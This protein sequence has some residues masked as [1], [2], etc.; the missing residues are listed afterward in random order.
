MI[1]PLIL[2]GAQLANQ[3]LLAY[4]QNKRARELRAR[5]AIDPT[6]SAFRQAQQGLENQANNAQVAGYGQE[7]DNLN[8][9]ISTSIGEMKRAGL[10]SS[11]LFNGLTRVNQQK[12]RALREL[13]IRGQNEQRMRKDRLVDAQMKRGLY[14]ELGRQENN[15]AIGAL[16][17]ASIQNV[18]NMFT[19]SLGLLS[20]LGTTPPSGTTSDTPTTPTTPTPTMNEGSNVSTDP[21]FIGPQN[22]PVATPFQFGATATPSFLPTETRKRLGRFYAGQP[23]AAPQ[24]FSTPDGQYPQGNATYQPEVYKE[25]FNRRFNP[26][27]SGF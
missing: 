22:Q 8:E 12:N 18:N 9:G 5:G 26:L 2:G 27:N 17:G 16:E 23:V 4:K 11:N 19:G 7:V 6:P 14:Q 10:T 21:N 13:S 15:E 1:A 25:L 20:S 3:G 24:T